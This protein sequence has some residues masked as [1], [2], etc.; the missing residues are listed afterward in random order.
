MNSIRCLLLGVC[1]LLSGCATQSRERAYT[2]I[3][4]AWRTLESS[5]NIGFNL[6]SNAIA[7]ITPHLH[8]ND[9]ELTLTMGLIYRERALLPEGITDELRK[10][11][12]FCY[13]ALLQRSS[14]FGDAGAASTLSSEHHF[15]SKFVAKDENLSRCWNEVAQETKLAA[16]CVDESVSIARFCGR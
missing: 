3:G 6:V 5:E 1:I 9:G 4:D 7:E 8:T 12:Y 14:S 13:L 15:G 16:A 10:K 11:D 2:E